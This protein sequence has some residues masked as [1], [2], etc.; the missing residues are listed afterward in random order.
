MAVETRWFTIHTYSGYENKVEENIGK[1]AKNSN[2]QDKIFK[3]RI[4]LEKVS[5]LKNVSIKSLGTMLKKGTLSQEKYDE[6][7]EEYKDS[8]P[9]MDFIL[10]LNKAEEEL[11]RGEITESAYESVKGKLINMYPDVAEELG[12]SMDS[13]KTLDAKYVTEA[14]NAKREVSI[15]VERKVFPSYVMVKL[16]IEYSEK[17]GEEGVL[18]VPDE[19]W[20]AIRY[21]SGVTGFV[22]PDGKPVPLTAEEVAN[23]GLEDGDD[24]S[25]GGKAV[26]EVS[27]ALGDLVTITEGLMEGNSGVVDNIDV[28]NGTVRVVVSLMGKEVPVELPLN[29][30]KKAIE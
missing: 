18:K 10:T 26:T 21:T 23:L 11:N 25:V 3:A 20:H 22:G 14:M 27:Y 7:V 15:E 16:A 2:M 12:I 5:E 8:S 13:D 28:D 1:I 29:Q 17:E 30:V 6:L 4:P 19:V 9:R 24:A